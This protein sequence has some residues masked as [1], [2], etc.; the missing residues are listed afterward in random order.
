MRIGVVFL[1]DNMVAVRAADLGPFMHYARS[2][3]RLA[4]AGLGWAEIRRADDLPGFA[5]PLWTSRTWA[6]YDV[7]GDR[8][9]VSL[10]SMFANLVAQGELPNAMRQAAPNPLGAFLESFASEPRE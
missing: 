2:E 8:G 4:L 5:K 10:V 3:V 6:F 7:S 1:P 9:T